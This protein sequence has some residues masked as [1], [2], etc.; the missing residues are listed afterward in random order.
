[1]RKVLV[2]LALFALLLLAASQLLIRPFV[3]HPF[4]GA[5]LYISKYDQFFESNA[6]YDAV[7]IGSSRTFR[8][9]DPFIFDSI[10]ELKSF[11]FGME[12]VGCPFNYY[13]ADKV[14]DSKKAEEIDYIVLELFSPENNLPEELMSDVNQTNKALFWYDPADFIF[15]FGALIESQSLTTIEKY[16]EIKVHFTT[17]IQSLLK[18]GHVQRIVDSEQKRMHDLYLG[19]R[20]DG[21]YSYDEEIET[22]YGEYLH[23]RYEKIRKDQPYFDERR[24]CSSGEFLSQFDQSPELT[25]HREYIEELNLKCDKKGIQLILILH[26]RMTLEQCEYFYRFNVSEIQNIPVLDYSS[27]DR[28]SAYYQI[29]NVFDQGHLNTK[30][31]RIFTSTL[32]DDFNQLVN[33]QNK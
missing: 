16:R 24:T 19:S 26:P 21:F 10:T 7:F 5:P 18:I 9:T 27:S 6:Q 17:L 12:E 14:L 11:N 3:F 1:M 33:P 25:F 29:E 30:G 4:W 13:M 15:S 22:K 23:E 20:K 32:A 2:K 31:A 8:N 28:Y